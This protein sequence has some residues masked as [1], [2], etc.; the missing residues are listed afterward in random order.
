MRN[1]KLRLGKYT[2]VISPAAPGFPVGVVHI[3]KVG[4]PYHTCAGGGE[5]LGTAMFELVA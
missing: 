2:G 4:I 5:K 3:C 1:A